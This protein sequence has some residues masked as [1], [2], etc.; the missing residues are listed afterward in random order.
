MFDSEGAS[1]T[2]NAIYEAGIQHDIFA[3]LYKA[4]HMVRIPPLTMQDDT[5]VVS[6]GGFKTSQISVFINTRTNIINLQ[7][8]CGKCYQIHIGNKFYKYI[9]TSLSID[10]WDK[11]VIEKET[12]DKELIDEYKGRYIIKKNK[13][14]KIPQ[15][16]PC[17]RWYKQDNYQGKNQKGLWE[18]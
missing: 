11:K 12:D 6:N 14:E 5:L 15:W 3:L 16:Y 4:N 1:I 10:A 13:K 7:F 9:W 17:R 8:G 2:Q 18:C